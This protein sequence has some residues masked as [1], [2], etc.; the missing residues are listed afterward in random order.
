MFQQ[1]VYEEP[2]AD[3]FARLELSGGE[4]AAGW[5]AWIASRWPTALD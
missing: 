4:P 5:P 1:E 2:N 3:E